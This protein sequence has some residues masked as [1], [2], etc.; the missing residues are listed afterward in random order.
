MIELHKRQAA[1]DVSVQG[2]TVDLTMVRAQL[3]QVTMERLELSTKLGD[4]ADEFDKR[5]EELV[6]VHG[7][8]DRAER[9][10]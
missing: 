8:R 1:A 7:A 2:M 9:L 4:V 5:L 3:V 10:V 6:V